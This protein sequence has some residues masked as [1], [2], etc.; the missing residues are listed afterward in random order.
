MLIDIINKVLI[1]ILF[2]SILN[3]LR[4]SYYFLQAWVKSITENPEKYKL[5]NKSLWIL[6][7]SISYILTTIFNGVLLS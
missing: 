4:H 3:V 6:S 1:L 7:L 5:S 2:M